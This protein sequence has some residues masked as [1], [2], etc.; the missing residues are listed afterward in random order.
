MA[1]GNGIGAGIIPTCLAART[2]LNG[3]K[4]NAILNASR[5]MGN[6]KDTKHK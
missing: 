5:A 4:L 2:A 1:T 6:T 3:K